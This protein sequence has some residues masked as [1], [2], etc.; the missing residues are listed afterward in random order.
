[1]DRLLPGAAE[2]AEHMTETIAEAQDDGASASRDEA[3]AARSRTFGQHVA[4][5]AFNLSAS[6][7]LRELSDTRVALPLDLCH[8]A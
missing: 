8:L 3:Q 5:S 4:D 6:L 2:A 1:M 7:S